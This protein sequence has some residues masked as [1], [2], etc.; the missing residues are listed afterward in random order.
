M[1][2]QAYV[3]ETGLDGRGSLL[4][5]SSL[6]ATAF[7]WANFSDRWKSVLDES[8]RIDYFK[9]DEAVGFSEQFYGVSE[10]QRN[11]K[12]VRLAKAIYGEYPIIEHVVTADLDAIRNEL[13]PRVRKPSSDPYFWPF[14]LTIGSIGLSLLLDAEWDESFEIFFDDHMIFGSWRVFGAAMRESWR[15]NHGKSSILLPR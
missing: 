9:M 10:S 14:Q 4:L 12:L 7:D 11:Y 13:K 8:P 3:D 15:R 5:F 6:L 2:I 1:S